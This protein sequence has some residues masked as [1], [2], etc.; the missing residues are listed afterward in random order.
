MAAINS[1][2]ERVI[3]EFKSWTKAFADGAPVHLN[4]PVAILHPE[5]PQ[6]ADE[7]LDLET[8]HQVRFELY[9]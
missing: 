1:E 9:C 6:T 3:K 8:T 2:S 5:L 4:C 7:M